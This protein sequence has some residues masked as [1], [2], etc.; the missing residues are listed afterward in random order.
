MEN[1][2]RRSGKGAYNVIVDAV[3]ITDFQFSQLFKSAIEG[4]WEATISDRRS[5]SGIYAI[6]TDSYSRWK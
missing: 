5:R 1:P 2:F 6:H 3:S 4:G